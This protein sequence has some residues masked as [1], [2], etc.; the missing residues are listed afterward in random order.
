VLG[1]VGAD[2]DASTINAFHSSISA[3]LRRIET[4]PVPVVCVV[5]GL[6]IAGGLEIAA[7][8]DIVVAVEDARF[9]DGHSTYGL[10]PGG[11]G[12][13]RRPRKV[14]ANRAKLLML[15]GRQVSASTMADWA[16]SASSH[17]PTH[18]RTGSRR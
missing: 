16:S 18:S 9:G 5:N 1:L 8:C 6:A 3:L 12:S 2:S 13:V 7:A 17:L 15:T 11:G 4:L 14:G 10:L